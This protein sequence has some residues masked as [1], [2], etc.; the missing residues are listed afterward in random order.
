ME[1][2]RYMVNMTNKA[3]RRLLQPR[4]KRLKPKDI[5]AQYIKAQQDQPGLHSKFID[6]EIGKF[7]NK[8]NIN[9]LNQNNSN[10][11]Y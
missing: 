2:L 11:R 5:A 6:R 4:R 1:W 8:Y 9:K 7:L 10:F 3:I